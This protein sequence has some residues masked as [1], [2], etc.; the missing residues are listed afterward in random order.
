MDCKEAACLGA[1]ILAGKAIGIFD[2]I[3]A[4]CEGMISVKKVYHPNPE[5]K[6]VY[7]KAYEKYKKVFKDLES[8]FEL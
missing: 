8:A 2:S 3:E 4:A 5:N 1:A 7:D 6:E